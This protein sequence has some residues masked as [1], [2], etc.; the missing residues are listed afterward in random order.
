MAKKLSSTEDEGFPIEAA[1]WERMNRTP[2][3][4][5]QNMTANMKGMCISY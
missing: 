1:I 2:K 4:K 5:K 3:A